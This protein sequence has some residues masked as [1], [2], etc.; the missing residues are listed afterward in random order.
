METKEPKTVGE[1]FDLLIGPEE[2][3]RLTA[4]AKLA[5]PLKNAAW[6]EWRMADPITLHDAIAFKAAYREFGQAKKQ[7]A[8]WTKKKK[9][10][11]PKIPDKPTL[12][13][14]DLKK[15]RCGLGWS[16][17]AQSLAP[18]LMSYV[19]DAIA[20]RVSKLYRQNRLA[21]LTFTDRVP[22]SDHPQILFREKACR[23]VHD[24]RRQG[25]Y[26]VVLTLDRK[27]PLNIAIRPKG[28]SRAT[29]EWLEEMAT[30]GAFPSGGTITARR[31]RTKQLWQISLS[32]IRREGEREKV[33][34]I[35]GRTLLVWAPPDQQEFLRCLVQPEPENSPPWQHTIEGHDLARLKRRA[36]DDRR[37]LG[38]NYHQSPQSA[39]HGHG[40]NRAIQSTTRF[41]DRYRRR[42][43]NWIEN[44]TA[45]IV[46]FALQAHCELLRV[47]NLSGRDPSKLRLGSFPYREFLNRLA[48]K[49]RDA[50]LQTSEF[51]DL[52]KVIKTLRRL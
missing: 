7:H 43:L 48:Q 36:E 20:N 38:R 27:G 37:R 26:R 44:R 49:G 24:D 45:E 30:S 15:A 31:R 28:A 21:Y 35:P 52:D 22:F 16:K 23:I 25:W 10:P 41:A 47:E 50:G 1:V 4:I 2:R 8:E 13:T 5:V 42:V 46:R 6:L 18:E 12:P 34:P 33:H 29:R 51:T 17:W 19:T 39:A 32:R 9:G 11:E 40:R 14:L 3:D